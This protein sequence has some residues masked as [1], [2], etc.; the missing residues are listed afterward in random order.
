MSRDKIRD[1][2]DV[3]FIA[4][5]YY[6]QLSPD[7]KDMLA[8]AL[9]YKDLGQFDYLIRTQS[10]PLIDPVQLKDRFLS[11]LDKVGLLQEEPRKSQNS[12]T[13][14]KSETVDG[15]YL[16]MPD[17]AIDNPD[18]WA[19]KT[20]RLAYRFPETQRTTVWR[21]DSKASPSDDDGAWLS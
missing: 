21:Q 20:P 10:D 16:P 8:M 13:N 4:D 2:F 11:T 1:L 18:E 3:S 5:K 6:D 15:F 19:S 9:E 17:P 7:A 12:S 14:D